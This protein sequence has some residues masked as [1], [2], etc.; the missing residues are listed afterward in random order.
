[1][2]TSLFIA[3]VLVA[4]LTPIAAITYIRPILVQVLQALCHGQSGAEFWVRCAYVLAVCGTLLLVLTFGEFS[5]HTAFLETIRRSLILVFGGVFL[6]IVIISR[7]VWRGV[8]RVLDMT[9]EPL[10]TPEAQP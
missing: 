5:A 6:T 2:D 3:S 10:A 4:V 1:M 8:Q 9:G 7:N